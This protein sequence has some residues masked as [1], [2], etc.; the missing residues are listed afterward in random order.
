MDKD[1]EVFILGD[2]NRDLMNSQIKQNWIDYMSSH[3]LIQH[4]N[5]PTRVFLTLVAL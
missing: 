2:F 5:Q 3:G 1:K 4:V